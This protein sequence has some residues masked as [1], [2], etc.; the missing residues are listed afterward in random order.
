[1]SEKLASKT[2][3]MCG[4]ILEPVLHAT[5][6]DSNYNTVPHYTYGHNCPAQLK[7]YEDRLNEISNSS[8]SSEQQRNAKEVA[9]YMNA[10]GN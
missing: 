1:M 8:M 2:C 5:S 7:K 9:G 3:S 6:I 10:W 4:G